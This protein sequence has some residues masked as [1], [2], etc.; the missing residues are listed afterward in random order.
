MRPAAAIWSVS[1][2][3]WRIRSFF[4]V[5]VSIVLVAKGE[6]VCLLV[7]FFFFLEMRKKTEGSKMATLFVLR[8]IAWEFGS[9]REWVLGEKRERNFLILR[10]VLLRECLRNLIDRH[11]PVG[12]CRGI[13]FA[14]FWGWLLMT[15]RSFQSWEETW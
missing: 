11:G 9:N 12:Q 7:C 14:A 10:S 8:R 1:E 2:R 6:R 5:G 13:W 4:S 3:L 15:V